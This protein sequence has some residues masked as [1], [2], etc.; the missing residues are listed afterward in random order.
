[1]DGNKDG[2]VEG[3]RLDEVSDYMDMPR[4]SVTITCPF[5]GV[6]QETVLKKDKLDVLVHGF[7]TI[8]KIT[9]CVLFSAL[10]VLFIVLICLAACKDDSGN[11]GNSMNCDGCWYCFWGTPSTPSGDC[12][13]CNCDGP[14]IRKI[15]KCSNCKETIG[16]CRKD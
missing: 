7:L 4:K 2:V 5:C 12:G 16:L 3:Q 1:M 11:M 13:C 6:T 8:L 10:I 14:K 15:H 9:F